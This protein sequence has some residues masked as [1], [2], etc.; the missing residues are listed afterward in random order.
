MKEIDGITDLK[1]KIEEGIA[2]V[3]VCTN[4]FLLKLSL[5]EELV[6]FPCL[7]RISL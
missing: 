2:S 3:E 4:C 7:R 5:Y 1:V 6:Y